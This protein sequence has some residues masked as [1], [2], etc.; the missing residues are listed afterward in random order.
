MLGAIRPKP[1]ACHKFKTKQNPM[2][3]FMIRN[4][5]QVTLALAVVAL[6]AGCG[7]KEKAVAVT[8]APDATAATAPAAVPGAAQPAAVVITDVNQAFAETD[9][10]LKAKAY[11]KA[12]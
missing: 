2:S 8:P 11:E 10:A 9:A 12:V 6:A 5:K 3:S 4:V 1:T 7:K